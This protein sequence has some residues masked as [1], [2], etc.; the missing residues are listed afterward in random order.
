MQSTRSKGVGNTR[1]G[2]AARP[3]REQPAPASKHNRAAKLQQARAKLLSTALELFLQRGFDAITVAEIA[4]AAGM[5]RRSFFRYF[6]SKEELVFDWLLEQGAFITRRVA[7]RDRRQPPLLAIRAAMIEL[8]AQMDQDRAP[9]SMLARIVF[10]TPALDRR[11][12]AETERWTCAI[13]DILRGEKRLRPMEEFTLRIQI[14]A[15]AAA[16]LGAMRV[17]AHREHSGTLSRWVE[18]AH[19]ALESGFGLPATAAG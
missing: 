19:A 6:P 9:A 1:G 10:D 4:D 14:S 12:S 3:R 7:G 5:S 15:T 13:I 17:W 2:G 18:A 11:F 8:A 16:F